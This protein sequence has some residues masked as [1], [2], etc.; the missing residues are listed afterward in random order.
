MAIS[1]FA[2]FIFKYPLYSKPNPYESKESDYTT[3]SSNLNDD[4]TNNS[5]EKVLSSSEIPLNSK[6]W[7]SPWNEGSGYASYSFNKDSVV[8]NILSSDKVFNHIQLFRQNI[9]LEPNQ[10]YLLRLKAKSTKKFKLCAN[11]TTIHLI[12]RHKYQSTVLLSLHHHL[13]I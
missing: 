4:A 12:Q 3:E 5:Y 6:Y 11:S 1:L 2:I 10:E 9:K 7:E 13:M 8:I